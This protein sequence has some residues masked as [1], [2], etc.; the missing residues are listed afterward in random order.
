MYERRFAPAP[1]WYQPD[2]TVLDSK[3][4]SRLVIE[5]FGRTADVKYDQG[6]AAKLEFWSDFSGDP[7]F[8]ALYPNVVKDRDFPDQLRASLE[9]AGLNLDPPM[10]DE[11]VLAA[12]MNARLR[13]YH[14]A[15]KNFVGLVRKSMHT[16]E[17]LEEGAAQHVAVS[18]AER[19]DIAV[20]AYGR[21]EARLERLDL[22]DFDGILAR[23]ARIVRSGGG[24]FSRS[25]GAQRGDVRAVRF[26]HVDELQDLSPLFMNLIDA[27][28]ESSQGSLAVF[29]VGTTGSRS[30]VSRVRTSSCS[31]A[32]LRPHLCHSD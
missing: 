26:L 22:D 28:R 16:I 32:S 20:D 2:F 11:Q 8:L 1:F 29:G 30:T 4:Q 17:T 12:S 6:T 24:K 19:I 15:V 7:Q 23:A 5:Y 25:S 9:R 10:D 21:Y 3:G 13:D 18:G 14:V 31:N 27:M